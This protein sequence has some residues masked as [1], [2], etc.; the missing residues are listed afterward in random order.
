MKQILLVGKFTQ[1]FRELNKVLAS[2]Y[3][4]RTCVNKL[5]IFNGMYQMNKPD[6]IMFLIEQKEDSDEELL[7]ALKKGYK[8]VPVI[9]SN[10]DV[11][12]EWIKR[13][14][15]SHRFV[16]MP[17]DSTIDEFFEMI[18][19]MIK[20]KESGE[21]ELDLMC[22]IGEEAQEEEMKKTDIVYS[23]ATFSGTSNKKNLLLVDDSGFALRTIRG[24]IG[25]KYDVRM[26][27]SGLDAISAIYQ[28]KPDLILLD[29]Q[30]PLL[31][32][33]QTMEKIR[34]VEDAQDIPIVFVT[35]VNDKEHIKAVL[36]LKP[37]GYLLKPVDGDRLLQTID[38]ILL[39]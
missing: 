21:Y 18:E 13:Y 10:S 17:S 35:S 29:Y 19:Y 34:E 27:T 25:D 23:R 11:D 14:M 24:F 16:Y 4:V 28:K 8:E 9:C 26:V 7:E 20:R 38:G 31:D 12:D 32:G 22:D 33:K 5:E 6:A 3:D 36:D 39:K 15:R 37:A 2:M 30:M 1:R